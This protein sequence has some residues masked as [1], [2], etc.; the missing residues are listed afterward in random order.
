MLVRLLLD[1][2]AEMMLSTKSIPIIQFQNQCHLTDKKEEDKGFSEETLSSPS[3][4]VQQALSHATQLQQQA[5]ERLKKAEQEAEQ[6]Y[7]QAKQEIGIW[8]E[9]AKKKGYDEG[10]QKGS[11]EG[12]DQGY[13]EGLRQGLQAQEEE[14]KRLKEHWFSLNQQITNELELMGPQLIELMIQGVEKIT[15]QQFEQPSGVLENCLQQMMLEIGQRQ[16]CVIQVAPE[17]VD[18]IQAFLPQLEAL[19]GGGRFQVIPNAR[20]EITDCQFETEIEKI[21]LILD[22]QLTTLKEAWMQVVKK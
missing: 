2:E 21:E 18:R 5:Q 11:K 7:R 4:G 15:H 12:Y 9:E 13:E 17:N 20:L 1:E 19:N 10:H 6:L 16:R 14:L 3:N 8:E 22:D